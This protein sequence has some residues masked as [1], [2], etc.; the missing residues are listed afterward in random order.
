MAANAAMVPS[1]A[2]EMGFWDKFQ[3]LAEQ[4]VREGNLLAGER[5][6]E[7]GRSP[8]M[9]HM[10]TIRSTMDPADFLECSLD[11]EAGVLTCNPG[12]AI[13]ADPMRFRVCGGTAGALWR[14]GRDCTLDQAISLI[15]DE[16]VWIEEVHDRDIEGE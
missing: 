9:P 3:C 16:L 8:G 7:I 2:K 1:L 15:L 12:S 14:E 4:R 11:G 6:W 13:K 5:L 10:F